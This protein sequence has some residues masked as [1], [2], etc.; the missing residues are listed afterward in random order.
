[1]PLRLR[2]LRARLMRRVVPLL[3]RRVLLLG[4]G[5]GK[6]LLGLVLVL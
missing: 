5:P 3:L 6:G 2:L 1:M 4:I